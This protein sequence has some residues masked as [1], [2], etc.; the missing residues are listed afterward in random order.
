MNNNKYDALKVFFIALIAVFLGYFVLVGGGKQG[1]QQEAKVINGGNATQAQNGTLAS[2]TGASGTGTSGGCVID[3]CGI[4]KIIKTVNPNSSLS[5]FNFTSPTPY[6][7]SF[8]LDIDSMTTIPDQKSFSLAAG[9]SYSISETAQSGYSLNSISCVPSSAVTV[10]LA[11]RKVT[12]NNL[13][14]GA[15]ITCTFD[16]VAT[17]TGVPPIG[18]LDVV[19]NTLSSTGAVT[20]TTDPFTFFA[21]LVPAT[22]TL[23]TDN[24][25]ATPNT[26]IY[27]PATGTYTITENTASSYGLSG[28][29]CISLTG[30]S[31]FSYS[32]A[33]ATVHYVSGDHVTCTYTN[34]HN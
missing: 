16:N 14:T 29:Q 30:G 12:V 6:I 33:T 9:A 10:S 34:R 4:I 15:T 7:G 3:A 28:L 5:A 22:F 13:A 25:S 8:Y 11:T 1:A 21:N 27:H 17:V 24:T 20:H 26:Q 31:T 2:S 32:G 23:D 19:K 18:E